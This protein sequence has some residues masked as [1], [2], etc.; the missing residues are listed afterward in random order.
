[1]IE[2]KGGVILHQKPL[3]AVSD[4]NVFRFPA[5]TARFVELSDGMVTKEY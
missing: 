2:L 3:G 4:I 5:P 1:M